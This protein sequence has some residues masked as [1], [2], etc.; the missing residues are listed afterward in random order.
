MLLEE[1]HH[2]NLV[3]LIKIKSMA[4]KSSRWH[5]NLVDFR[6]KKK[7][8]WFVWGLWLLI[9][10]TPYIEGS[11]NP[12]GM[13]TLKNW[14][15]SLQHF[16][17]KIDLLTAKHSLDETVHRPLA[18]KALFANIYILDNLSLEVS[19]FVFGN[20]LASVLPE[21]HNS[22]HILTFSYSL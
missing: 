1:R 20:L 8:F 14:S 11:M 4:Q 10:D 22:L 7:L 2:K 6:S 19:V 13:W 18:L 15:Q 17:F 3:D 16:S 21:I 9:T 12:Y 5:K